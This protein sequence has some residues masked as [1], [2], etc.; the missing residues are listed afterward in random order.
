MPSA[1]MP[2]SQ[3]QHTGG[4]KRARAGAAV[5]QQQGAARPAK[6]SRSG[7]EPVARLFEP[8]EMDMDS[9]GEPSE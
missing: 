4:A 3:A 5:A 1:A 8:D 2:S 7:D 9:E 6:A